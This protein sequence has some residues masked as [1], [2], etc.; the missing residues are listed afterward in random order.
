[1]LKPDMIVEPN[2]LRETVLN[3]KNRDKFSLLLDITAVDYLKYPVK[4]DQRF[5]THLYF[6]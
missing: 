3:L 1:M 2:K 5:C 6:T 4:F